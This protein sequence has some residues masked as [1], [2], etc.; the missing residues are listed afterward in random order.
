MFAEFKNQNGYLSVEITLVFTMILFS[1]MLIVF[2]GISLYQQTALQSSVQII[3]SQGAAM[4]ASGSAELTTAGRSLASYK[5][6]NPYVN[7]ADSSAKRGAENSIRAAIAA[8]SNQNEVYKGSNPS[9]GARIERSFFSQSVIVNAARDFTMPVVSI[10]DT[11]GLTSPIRISVAAA[12]PVTN[13]V[14]VIR[15]TDICA[16]AL[17]YFDTTAAV[18]ERLGYFQGKVTGFIQGIDISE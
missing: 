14:E 3:A 12:A 6:Q 18:I 1:L 8:A 10:A 2:L 15:T 16:D 5:N 11:F 4:Y 7:F 13:P 9:A 17:M